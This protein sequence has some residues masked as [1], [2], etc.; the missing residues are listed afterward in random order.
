M[1]KTETT[2]RRRIQRLHILEPL[3]GKIRGK[4]VHVLDVSLRG[5][6]VAHGEILGPVGEECELSFEWEGQTVVLECRIRR[7]A[8]QRIGKA[9]Y[10][11]TLYH[12]GLEIRS[13]RS[14]DV[15]REIIESHVEK[16]LEE[17]KAKARGEED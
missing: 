5:V 3:P 4:N 1:L 2:E 12:S 13:G 6:R 9:S 16:V 10:A 17:Q 8:V 15:L 11:R 7:S 14:L